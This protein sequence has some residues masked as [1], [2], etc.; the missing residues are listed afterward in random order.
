MKYAAD[1]E[2]TTDPRDCRVW[3]WGLYE[4]E[5]ETFEY[6]NNLDEFFA[7]F[8]KRSATVYFHNLKF[9]GEFILYWLYRHGFTYYESN[10]KMPEKTFTTLISDSGQWYTM[11]ICMRTTRTQS[12]RLKINDSLKLLPFSV[13]E[14]A[15]S[16]KMDDQKG[17]IDYTMNRPVGY[18]LT[19]DEIEYIRKDVAIV[20]HALKQLFIQNMNSITIG[21]N[22]LKDYKRVLGGRFFEYYFPQPNYDEDVR[23]SYRGG[24]TYLN[25]KYA[26]REIGPGIVLD[27]N[28]LYPYV[29]YDRPMPVGDGVY[30]DGQ[31]PDNRIYPLY[32]QMIKCQFELKP[33]HIPTIQIKTPSIYFNP[34]E[35]VTSSGIEEITLCLTSVDLQLFMDQ[36]DVYNIEYLGGWMFHSALGL[37]SDYIDKWT[38]AKVQAKVEN[39]HGLY[40]LAKLMLNSL[41]GKFATNPK[42][43][44]KV[45]VYDPTDDFIHLKVVDQ[46]DRDPVYIPAGTFI[47][48]YAREITIR[49]A[50][51]VYDRFIYAD[52]DSLHLL[53]TELPNLDI[54]PA[55][56]GAWD[57]ELT[58]EKGFY[59]RS[60]TYIEIGHAPGETE[61]RLKVTCAGMPERLHD[62]VTFE[63][64]RKGKV[65]HNKLR[66][67][68]VPGGVVLE[69]SNFRI[70][71]L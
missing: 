2:T 54:D 67:L 20:G 61:S 27:V 43:K 56:L 53:G 60:K 62:Q 17:K 26:S 38:A 29:M 9:D 33:G 36:Y 34:V 58:F 40:I 30:F 23:L 63:N 19:E 24:F 25:P 13:S 66:P 6:G 22:A 49:A 32:V 41:Y 16:F 44:S 18:E 64:F 14:I 5:S 57:H 4:I 45:P 46:D 28:S 65:Y 15:R 8:M 7:R 42:V 1:F 52:T 39:N 35:Y 69:N 51:T 12:I 59:I 70:K 37:F 31:Y 3:A 48:A 50:Q 11:T 47:T 10:K 71:D 68:R 55:R 21:A